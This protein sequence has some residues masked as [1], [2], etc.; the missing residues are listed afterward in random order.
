MRGRKAG[1]FQRLVDPRGEV[2]QA[3]ARIAVL[4][5]TAFTQAFIHVQCNQYGHACDIT[6][7]R[8]PLRRGLQRFPYN[9]QPV[10]QW[11]GSL[12]WRAQR[13]NAQRNRRNVWLF[14]WHS[15]PSATADFSQGGL[16]QRHLRCIKSWRV[17]KPVEHVVSRRIPRQRTQQAHQGSGGA[18]GRQLPAGFVTQR[19]A[20]VSQHGAYPAGQQTVLRNQCDGAAP[21]S[22]MGECAG[23]GQVRFVLQVLCGVQGQCTLLLGRFELDADSTRSKMV[24]ERFNQWLGLKA[25]HHH[26]Q[27]QPRTQ[28][29]IEQHIGRVARHGGPGQCN[30]G[31][32]QL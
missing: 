7:Q 14:G 31:D 5:C 26:Q 17:F 10:C 9:M 18:G 32:G 13:R 12:Q 21:C 11:A 1:G 20:F 3:H 16:S 30:A 25:I 8:A 6:C 22:Q 27:I 28:L 29:G 4:G 23:C 19:H 2:L 15:S 24:F